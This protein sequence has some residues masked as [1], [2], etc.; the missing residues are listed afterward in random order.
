MD[1]VQ[2]RNKELNEN[3]ETFK[4]EESDMMSDIKAQIKSWEWDLAKEEVKILC[5]LKLFSV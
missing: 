3:R 4:K 5:I 1:R 2:N